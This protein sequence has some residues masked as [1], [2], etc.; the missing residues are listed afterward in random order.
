MRLAMEGYFLSARTPPTLFPV[1]TLIHWMEL[2]CGE[3]TTL[4]MA[5]KMADLGDA[6]FVSIRKT[7]IEPVSLCE[8]FTEDCFLSTL[9][10]QVNRL[11]DT[12]CPQT[13]QVLIVRIVRA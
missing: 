7:T 11:S 9:R 12:Q 2:S 13:A 8:G 4:G 1:K 3:R 6:D 5:S 10:L